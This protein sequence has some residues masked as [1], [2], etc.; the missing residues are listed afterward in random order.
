MRLLRIELWFRL[1]ISSESCKFTM[2]F[3]SGGW[4]VSMEHI[5][6]KIYSGGYGESRELTGI[7]CARS[8]QEPRKSSD[9]VVNVLPFS[10]FK[11]LQII[12]VHQ[13]LS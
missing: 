10:C 3:E 9:L 12:I 11:P 4:L 6:A 1:V 2:L 13:T 5:V 7:S 8:T